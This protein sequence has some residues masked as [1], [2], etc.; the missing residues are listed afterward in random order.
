MPEMDG[1]E[2]AEAISGYSKSKDI[3]IIFL[4]AVNTHKRFIT[5]GYTSGGIDYITKPFDP[6]IL[7]LK[8]KIFKKLSEQTRLLNEL[9][10]N[11]KAEIEIRKKAEAQLHAHFEELKSILESIPQVAFTTTSE[12]SIEFVNQYWYRYSDSREDFPQAEGM[13]IARIVEKSIAEGEQT[14]TEVKIKQLDSEEY[15]YHLLYLTPVVKNSAIVKWVGILN[16]IHEQKSASDVL[17]KKV[18]ERTSELR[19][20]NM[21]LEASNNELRQ[22]AFIAS[23]DLQE[24]LRKI[25]TFSNL[26]LTRYAPENDKAVPYLQK[27]SNSADRLRKLVVDL[28]DYASIKSEENFILTDMNALIQEVLMDLELKIKNESAYIEIGDLPEIEV[29]PSLMLQVFQNLMTN[30]LKFRKA[31]VQP[32]IKVTGELIASKSIDALPDP[33]GEFCRII[34]QDNGIGFDNQYAERIFEI[35]QRLN[36]QSSYEGTGIGLAITKKVIDRH[37]GLIHAKSEENKGTAF[38]MVLP[39]KQTTTSEINFA[40]QQ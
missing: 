11:L 34:V 1:F 14:V 15:K 30:S 10:E 31:G 32:C 19:D 16:D 5:K 39:V 37:N 36:A 9:S 6:D 28:L 27:I 4:S 24:P 7:L 33:S 2:V 13:S 20:I 3:P 18:A 26:V 38:I 8:V 12:G 25:Q 21:R 40:N 35:F 22:F 23:H 29:M 17:E